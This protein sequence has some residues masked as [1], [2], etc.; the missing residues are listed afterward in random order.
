MKRQMQMMRISLNPGLLALL[1]LTAPPLAQ[2]PARAQ[3]R[4]DVSKLGPQVGERVPDFSL[5]DQNGRTQT[6]RSVLGPKGGMLVF[7]RSADW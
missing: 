6:L 1:L 5:R 2:T 4:I 7:V 3:E